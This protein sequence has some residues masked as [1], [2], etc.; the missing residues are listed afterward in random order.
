MRRFILL[1]LCTVL[2][3][4]FT[5][6]VSV[7]VGLP[8]SVSGKG[9]PET[10]TFTV[11]E[12]SSIYAEGYVNIEYYSAPSD[13]VTL[14]IQP[15]LREYFQVEVQN[16][17]LVVKTAK[18]I[19]YTSKHTPT[20]TVST[21][22]LKKLTLAGAGNFTAHDTITADSFDLKLSGAGT[23]NV[24]LDVESCMIDMS[25]AGT[26][27]LSG[28]ADTAKMSMSGAGELK[29]L[30]LQTANASVRLSGAG[31]ITVNATETLDI[32]ASGVGYVGYKGGAAVNTNRSGVV[33]VERLD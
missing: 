13:T 29:A 26:F 25:G 16:G 21:P 4:T 19:N 22:V 28:S 2:L 24:R 27:T 1:T 6:C 8:G 23:G 12:Y 3:L 18:R 9:D 7:N 20:L 33:S 5:G 11:G 31:S 30:G 14:E 17:E 10:Y 32:T 15:N